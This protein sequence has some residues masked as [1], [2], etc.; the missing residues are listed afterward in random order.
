M[1]YRLQLLGESVRLSRGDAPVRIDTRAGL[2]LAYLAL[3]GPTSRDRL[4][5]LL[6]PDTGRGRARG[7]LRQLLLRLRRAAPVVLEAPVHLDANV[8]VDVHVV[9]DDPV[10]SGEAGGL[11]AAVDAGFS[12]ALEEWLNAERTRFAHTVQAGLAERLRAAHVSGRL[13]LAIAAARRSLAFEPTSEFAHR[14]LMALQLEAR[15][16]SGALE[17]SRRCREVLAMHF[18][19]SPVPETAALGERA[20][21][22]LADQVRAAP[23]APAGFT[24]HPPDHAGADERAFAAAALARRAEAGG[25]LREGAALLSLAATDT[26]DAVERGA[27]LVNLAWLEHQRGD[28]AAATVAAEAGVAAL[29]GVKEGAALIDGLFVLGSLASHQGDDGAAR[30]LWSEALELLDG[31]VEASAGTRGRAGLHLNLG[32]VEDALD[33]GAAAVAHYLAAIRAARPGIDDPVLAIALNNLGHEL[34]ARGR[35]PEAGTLLR[36]ALALARAA[37]DRQ[38]EGH[39][40]D[41]LAHVAVTDGDARAAR[42]LASRAVELARTVGDAGLEMDALTTLAWAW[43]ALGDREAA[44]AVAQTALRVVGSRGS[45]TRVARAVLEFAR[46]SGPDVARAGPLLDA[47]EHDERVPTRFREAARHVP[48]AAGPPSP[49]ATLEEALRVTLG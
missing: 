8:S 49:A 28:D 12:P 36:K 24:F 22:L 37:G 14:T 27:I 16:A 45:P 2:L 29:R 4:A 3:A 47:L 39:A 31:A 46:S 15:D 23:V 11:L 5:E 38:L 1:P 33:D 41:G 26:E 9:L 40:L 34:L 20:A 42:S 44:V 17:T 25:W 35:S 10:A 21:A 43:R 48:R 19:A 13:D 7:N 30:A 6:W 18:D 32:L